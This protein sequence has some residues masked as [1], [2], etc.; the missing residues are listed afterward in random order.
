LKAWGFVDVAQAQPEE[1]SRQM[2]RCGRMMKQSGIGGLMMGVWRWA[3]L[4]W[5]WAIA[6]LIIITTYGRGWLCWPRIKMVH[7]SSAAA[8]RR[9]RP[10][11]LITP[12][13][14]ESGLRS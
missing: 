7:F 3:R 8:A 4:E 10:S 2:R 14:S 9:S 1:T 13:W 11:P 6:A 12:S 5:T